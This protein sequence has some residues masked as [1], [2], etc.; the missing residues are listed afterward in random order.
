[1]RVCSPALLPLCSPFRSPFAHKICARR[2]RA[3]VEAEWKVKQVQLKEEE[4][5]RITQV[6]AIAKKE[7]VERQAREKQEMVKRR[8]REEEEKQEEVRR[9]K[10]MEEDCRRQ[11]VERQVQEE[12]KVLERKVLERELEREREKLERER[13][14]QEREKIERMAKEEQAI[15]EQMGA[16]GLNFVLGDEDPEFVPLSSPSRAPTALPAPSSGLEFPS[17]QLFQAAPQG[18]FG[19]AAL[20]APQAGPASP[21]LPE[22]NLSFFQNLRSDVAPGPTRE[23][24][25][26][27]PDS[28]ASEANIDLLMTTPMASLLDS[29]D[30]QAANNK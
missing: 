22:S 11:E 26:F 13:E 20:P 24:A 10:K 25:A 21:S 14:K 23:V 30:D 27:D 16:M 29:L 1:M 28:F 15:A 2:E 7:M 4:E 12:R 17:S 18:L 6:M 3:R 5:R 8:I 19:T 9:R